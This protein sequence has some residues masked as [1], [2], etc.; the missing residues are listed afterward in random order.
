[1]TVTQIGWQK[2]KNT[3]FVCIQSHQLKDCYDYKMFYISLMV[4]TKHKLTV[5]IQ[6]INHSTIHIIKRTQERKKGK[7]KLQNS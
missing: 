6:N 5:N 7:Q 4:T 3:V 2:C 1:M